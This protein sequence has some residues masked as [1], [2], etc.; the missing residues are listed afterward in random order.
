MRD[1][2]SEFT[3]RTLIIKDYGSW[4]DSTLSIHVIVWSN[5]KRY[6]EFSQRAMKPQSVIE[7][8]TV[9]QFNEKTQLQQHLLWLSIG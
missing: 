2:E 4:T 6:S 8:S 9:D 3:P 7:Q 1:S 5:S